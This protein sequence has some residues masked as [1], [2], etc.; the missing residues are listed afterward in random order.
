[1]IQTSL[2]E[3]NYFPYLPKRCDLPEIVYTLLPSACTLCITT[4]TLVVFLELL[5]KITL[6]THNPN[7]ALLNT[8]L[9]TNNNF[10]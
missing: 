3:Q 9:I 2:K 1:M 7:L 10:F 4:Y 5:L 8:L 6:L